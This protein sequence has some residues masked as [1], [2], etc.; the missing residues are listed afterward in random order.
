MARSVPLSRFASRV[1]G[2][3]AFFVRPQEPFEIF[4]V[5]MA[6]GD[7]RSF[8]F[9]V[10]WQQTFLEAISARADLVGASRGG[11]FFH[12][13]EILSDGFLQIHD[14]WP[15]TALEPTRITPSVCREV[16]GWRMSQF[17]RGSALDR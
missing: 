4:R 13:A 1:G 2:G 8:D 17:P 12:S 6:G 7:C 9:A 10:S 14:L 15:N 16:A 3:S 5:G 11:S